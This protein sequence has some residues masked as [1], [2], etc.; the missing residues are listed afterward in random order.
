MQPLPG[1]NVSLAALLCIVISLAASSSPPKVAFYCLRRSC[2]HS[3]VTGR[4]QISSFYETVH[5]VAW[6]QPSSVRQQC[7]PTP[8]PALW[9]NAGVAFRRL[10]AG[11]C[12]RQIEDPFSV[13]VLR[14]REAPGCQW[15]ERNAY[16]NGPVRARRRT[17]MSLT[18][19]QIHLIAWKTRAK[20]PIQTRRQK[21]ITSSFTNT[22]AANEPVPRLTLAIKVSP[23]CRMMLLSYGHRQS[24]AKEGQR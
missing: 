18:A 9:H 10:D 8:E 13:G 24:Q 15:R 6:A 4:V 23:R 20:N 14:G 7:A 11:C 16:V 5:Q 22:A 17:A 12:R 2:L 3:I 21:P 1:N 19:N